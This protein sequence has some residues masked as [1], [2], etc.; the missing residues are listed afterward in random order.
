MAVVHISY[1]TDPAD[2]WSWALE[3][4]LRRLTSEFGEDL[5]I[6][7]VMSGLERQFD[8]PSQMVGELLAAAERSGMPVDPRL[9]LDDP[10]RSSYPACIAVKAAAEQGDP[11]QYLRRLREGFMCRRRK[12]DTTDALMQEARST[13]GSIWTASASILARTRSSRPSAQISTKRPRSPLNTV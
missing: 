2:P 11:G 5:Q 1:Y 7:Y 10:P 12:L 13:P 8:T 9:W 3:P 4:A 6:D